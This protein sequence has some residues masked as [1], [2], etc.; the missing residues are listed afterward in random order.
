MPKSSLLLFHPKEDVDPVLG[1]Y[2]L[3]V[4]GSS[5]GGGFLR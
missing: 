4:E 5:F 1:K 2:L 3:V